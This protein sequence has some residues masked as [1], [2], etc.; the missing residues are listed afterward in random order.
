MIGEFSPLLNEI[1]AVDQVSHVVDENQVFNDPLIL[2]ALQRYSANSNS[3]AHPHP[4]FVGYT[5]K[6]PTGLNHIFEV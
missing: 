1:I 5:I 2:P 3:V 6:S 4:N